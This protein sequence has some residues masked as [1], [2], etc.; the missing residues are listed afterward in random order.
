MAIYIKIMLSSGII[1][2]LCLL[3]DVY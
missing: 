2:I 3:I 1:L